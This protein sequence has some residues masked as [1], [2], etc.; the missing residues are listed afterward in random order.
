MSGNLLAR[1]SKEL[2]KSGFP[3]ELRSG[4]AFERREWGVENNFIFED[5]DTSVHREL[6]VLACDAPAVFQNKSCLTFYVFVECKKSEKPWVFFPAN[7][8]TE[9]SRR[10]L[11]LS[12]MFRYGGKEWPRDKYN[13]IIHKMQDASHYSTMP[14]SSWYTEVFTKKGEEH[15][16]LDA[17]SK[18]A[19]AKAYVMEGT[20]EKENA[21][22]PP[23]IF[24]AYCLIVLDGVIINA[25]PGGGR[26]QPREAQHVVLSVNYGS[27]KV[28]D[29]ILIDVVREGYLNKYLKL[30]ESEKQTFVKEAEIS[31]SELRGRNKT[32]SYG[33]KS[34]VVKAS[35]N[36]FNPS[37]ARTS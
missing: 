11:A 36:A 28:R 19:K 23:F 24:I 27:P 37:A 16:I 8:S 9:N 15:D 14:V 1:I 34:E 30:I 7:S 22:D 32:G 31:Y 29:H 21:R 17:I 5:Q 26:L 4:Y 10:I 25:S 18:I 6:D 20:D 35:H 3:V 2:I 33:A 13:S 12:S